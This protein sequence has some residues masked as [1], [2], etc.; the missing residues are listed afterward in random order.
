[1][2]DYWV[3]RRLVTGTALVRSTWHR[4]SHCAHFVLYVCLAIGSQ[5]CVPAGD[6]NAFVAA[7]ARC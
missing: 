6:R 2:L 5:R 4:S 3:Q 1:M 7:T